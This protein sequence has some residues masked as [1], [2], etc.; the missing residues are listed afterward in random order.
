ME[1]TLVIWRRFGKEHGEGQGFRVNPPEMVDAH[2]RAKV[3][4]FRQTPPQEWR[5][6]QLSDEVIVERNG[7]EVGMGE[8][9]LIFYLPKR[10]WVLMYMPAWTYLSLDWTWLVHIGDIEFDPR[11]D[12]W[13]FT[14]LFAD[15]IVQEDNSTH[16]VL[17]LDDL[18]D[19]LEIGLVD[20]P[21]TARILRATQE[22]VNLIASGGFPPRELLGHEGALQ[23][24]GW[25]LPDFMTAE[26]DA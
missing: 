21:T 5:W 22:L 2:L 14:D 25:P 23:S 24:L 16:R 3:E 12:C 15:V 20:V 9:T 26:E 11:Y 18:A 17:D 8:S 10:H 19:A 1:K 7:A 4:M 6:W 13:V